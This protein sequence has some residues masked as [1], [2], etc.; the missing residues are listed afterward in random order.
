VLLELRT[1]RLRAHSMFD[2]QLYRDKAEVEEWRKRGPLTTLTTALKAAG[3][4]TEEDFQR[5]LRAA[6][7]EVKAAVQ[8]ATDAEWEPVADLARHVYAE[9]VSS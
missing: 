9:G 1:Y 4:L 3:L 2:A 5:L 6:D 8:L 7:E